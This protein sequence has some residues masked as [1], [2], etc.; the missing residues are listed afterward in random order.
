MKDVIS[1]FI[2][3]YAFGLPELSFKITDLPYEI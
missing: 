2:I 1:T 3:D